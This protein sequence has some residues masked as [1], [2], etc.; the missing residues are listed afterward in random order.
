ME[1]DLKFDEY[2]QKV[3]EITKG[4]NLVLA[5]PGCGKTAILAERIQY[6]H[7]NGV[8][9]E[10]MMC[11]TFT[12]RASKGM[13]ERIEKRSENPV[14]PEL[15]VGN[16]HRF[17]SQFLFTNRVINQNTAILDEFDTLSIL[18]GLIPKIP[19]E[20][21]VPEDDMQRID[22]LDWEQLEFVNERSQMQHLCRQ[23]IA[24]HPIELFLYPTEYVKIL[25]MLC[26]FDKD[27]LNK[28]SIIRSL[29]QYIDDKAEN[30]ETPD[31]EDVLSY[32][33]QRWGDGIEL[34]SYCQSEISL[35]FEAI[36]YGKYKAENDMLDFDDLLI[37]TYD[38]LN[39]FPEKHHKY[40]WIQIDEVQDLNRLQFA[41][42]DL[43]TDKDSVVVYLGDEQQAIFSFMGAKLETLEWLKE[44]CKGNIHF[45]YNNYRSPKYLLDVFNTYATNV[46]N[47]DS[48]LL[49]NTNNDAEHQNRDLYC[50]C[51]QDNRSDAEKIAKLSV[52]YNGVDGGTVAVLVP[53]NKEADLISEAFKSQNVEHF[54]VSGKD[55]FSTKELRIIIAHL[56]IIQNEISFTQWA[57]LL[58]HLGIVSGYSVARDFMRQMKGKA[59]LPNDLFLSRG[60]YLSDFLN[61]YENNEIVLFDTE[62][63]G[64]DVF[65]DDIVQIAAIKIRNGVK[66]P[67]SEKEIYMASDKPLPQII[68]GK[69]N[70]MIE[71]MENKRKEGKVVS[72]E[73][74]LKDFMEYCKGT[75]LIAHNIRYDYN[76]LKYNLQRNLPQIDLPTYCPESFDTLKL[77]RLLEPRLKVYK[78]VRLLEVL[79]LEGVNSHNAIDD[80]NATANLLDYCYKK[81]KTSLPE[82]IEFLSK[83]EVKDISKKLIEKY[84]SLYEEGCSRLYNQGKTEE[85]VLVEEMQIAYDYFKSKKDITSVDKWNHIKRYFSQDL[86]D[87]N[88]YSTLLDQLNAYITDINT[89]KEADLCAGKSMTEKYFISTVHKAKGLE[90]DNVIVT[91][92]VLDVY[93]NYNRFGKK[94]ENNRMVTDYGKIV[95][96][97][98]YME[99]ARKLYVAIS[100]AR[101]RLCL[102]WYRTRWVY[103]KKWHSWFDF[104]S[105]VSPFIEPI[106]NYLAGTS[107]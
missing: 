90:F 76:I 51:L 27:D 6:A 8:A 44:R 21:E 94:M 10:D 33:K 39:N 98:G 49:P 91:S 1:E 89:T 107:Q 84:K 71:V 80:V 78:L 93:P 29:I 43:S 106:S 5:P 67:G 38:E 57:K 70:P 60:S 20:L 82:Q 24:G 75:V 99:D 14:P 4:Y 19:N 105:M 56:N 9:Y 87:S 42:A 101:K 35:L 52:Q 86:I 30:S 100:R 13:K 34:D 88:K 36:K 15:F 68:A 53:T 18:I 54:K 73:A 59:L 79:N 103:S 77:I 37:Q 85:S 25:K 23:I 58:Y 3:I 74:G 40:K 63:T 12:N 97:A 31:R 62:T 65:N 17:C 81:G 11:L 95:D 96:R 22:N 48:D 66:V 102:V 47:I 2:Q 55:V 32:L 83:P 45:L 72:L 92:C 64:L 7:Q 46:L 69:P 104:P 28:G 16:L 61:T 50:A 26:L 41:I